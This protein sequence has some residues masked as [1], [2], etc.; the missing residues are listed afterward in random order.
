MKGVRGE[1]QKAS[2]TKDATKVEDRNK[3]IGA[4]GSVQ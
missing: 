1:A 4:A 2:K 3:E